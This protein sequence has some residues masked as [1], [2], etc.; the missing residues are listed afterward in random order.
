MFKLGFG[1]RVRGWVRVTSYSVSLLSAVC[2]CQT[3]PLNSAD[4]IS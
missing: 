1:V 2:K 3:L 4:S